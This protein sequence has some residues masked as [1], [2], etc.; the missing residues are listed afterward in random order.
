MPLHEGAKRTRYMA[1]RRNYVSCRSAEHLYLHW[2]LDRAAF[3]CAA[4]WDSLQQYNNAPSVAPSQQFIPE[5]ILHTAGNTTNV[6]TIP[7]NRLQNIG[8]PVSNQ[9]C[10]ESYPAESHENQ[11]CNLK[12][13]LHD[14]FIIEIVDQKS[15]K[16]WAICTRRAGKLYQI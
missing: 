4:L 13:E 6:G 1:S 11:L 5:T 3:F 14:K 15:R 10:L 9:R 7:R 16:P 2:D 12:E 8:Q